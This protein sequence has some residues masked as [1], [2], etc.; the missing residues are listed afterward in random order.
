MANSS[1]YLSGRDSASGQTVASMMKAKPA[2]PYGNMLRQVTNHVRKLQ[3]DLAMESSTNVEFEESSRRSF[4]F[5]TGQLKTLKAAFNTLSDTLLEELEH[6]S[7]TVKS[8]L[9]IFKEDPRLPSLMEGEKEIKEELASFSSSSLEKLKRLAEQDCYLESKVDSVQSDVDAVLQVI[10]KLEDSFLQGDKD[11][12]DRCSMLQSEITKLNDMIS[13][14]RKNTHQNM[15]RL[16]KR[17]AEG[18]SSQDEK[19]TRIQKS[20]QQQIEYVGKLAM[21]RTNSDSMQPIRK[22][23]N[24]RATSPFAAR[25]TSPFAPPPWQS[26]VSS[27]STHA[28]PS[29]GASEEL[30]AILNRATYANPLSSSG[31]SS[32]R[33]SSF[34]G[35]SSEK[36]IRGRG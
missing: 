5:L 20:L 21:S 23:E 34:L 15:E 2:V 24:A 13:N 3:E 6:M 26:N 22:P 9:Q 12:R 17:I 31:R 4:E 29:L 33:N 1:V 14:D 36:F 32:P 8:E 30:S 10:P 28:V 11:L 18:L 27:L 19:I 25:V 35:A 7:G 16:E